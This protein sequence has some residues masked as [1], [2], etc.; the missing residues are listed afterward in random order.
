MR[1]LWLVDDG[2]TLIKKEE[3]TCTVPFWR[4]PGVYENMSAR[5]GKNLK[6]HSHLSGP[7]PLT[8]PRARLCESR[9]LCSGPRSLCWGG[10]PLFFLAALEQT[11]TKLRRKQAPCVKHMTNSFIWHY[12]GKSRKLT[13]I[14]QRLKRGSVLRRWVSRVI[15]WGWW[16]SR[17]NCLVRLCF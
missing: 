14:L 9:L 8:S 5:R 6:V 12:W 10:L 13:S 1:C 17:A 11:R 2:L 16:D 7:G 15:G 4:I 3:G